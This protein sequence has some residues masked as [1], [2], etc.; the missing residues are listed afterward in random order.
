[1]A[2]TLMIVLPFPFHCR[3]MRPAS[4][5]RRFSGGCP[6]TK[7]PPAALSM[8]RLSS[9]RRGDDEAPAG[10]ADFAAGRYAVDIKH[11]FSRP[12]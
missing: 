12:Q 6:E 11:K 4:E 7:R 2:A 8:R 1:M 3:F 10:E 9:I 5:L